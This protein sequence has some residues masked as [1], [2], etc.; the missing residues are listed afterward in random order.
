MFRL[1]RY[2]DGK[3]VHTSKPRAEKAE[4]LRW[5]ENYQADWSRHI[6]D[7]HLPEMIGTN[8]GKEVSR[9][10]DDELLVTTTEDRKLRFIIVE[11]NN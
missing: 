10:S 1:R 11:R 2:V 8:Q 9:V 7:G 4:L 5:M 6:E 3:L